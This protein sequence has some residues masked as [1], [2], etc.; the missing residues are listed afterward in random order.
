M[1]IVFMLTGGILLIA[2][3][4]AGG[5]L[6]AVQDQNKWRAA[7]A[8]L[9]LLEYTRDSIRYKGCP[10]EEV[11]AAAAAY[12]EFAR[13]EFSSCLRFKELPIPE[14]FEPALRRELQGSL[15]A[16]ESCGRESA[17]QTL[18]SMARLCRPREETLQ[19]NARAALRLYPRLGGCLGALAAIVLI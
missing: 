5:F 9:R 8:F 13:L 3:G 2:C 10:A 11:F 15:Q 1:T 4:A 18:E 6:L 17:C 14:V 12:P 19:E 7:H 16:L